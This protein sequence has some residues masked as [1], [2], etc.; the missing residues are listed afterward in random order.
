M[1][2]A[3]HTPDIRRFLLDARSLPSPEGAALRL[4]EL[5]HDPES[6][7]D[8][9][10]DTIKADP[11]LTGF[12]LHA[13]NAAQYG[14]MSRATNL[15][16]AVL[17]LGTNIIRVHALAL[18]LA[19]Q[20][21]PRQCRGFDYA[22]FWTMGL[23]RAELMAAQARR[24]GEFSTED[25]FTIGLLAD[26]GKLVFATAAPEEYA[27]VIASDGAGSHCAARERAR[28]G[29]DHHELAAVVVTDWG[30]PTALADIIYWQHAPEDA[31]Y[32]AD[33]RAYRLSTALR[34]AAQTTRICLSPQAP[35]ER[36]VA[37][38]QLRAALGD[39]TLPQL[40]DLLT[41]AAQ[42]LPGWTRLAGLPTPTLRAL[43][44][45]WET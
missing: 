15:Y 36:T 14:A 38:L 12:I 24:S 18:S 40:V 19:R 32:P 33:S 11:A 31:G 5:A 28:F 27:A 21:P 1:S 34:L 29:F 30:L 37:E 23:L 26:I 8:Q 9:I 7:L 6:D 3:P 22:G 13:A 35:D 4:H 2:T 42:T 20:T 25:G 44:T 17:R 45:D 43:P 10:L 39:Y 16:Q 41:E